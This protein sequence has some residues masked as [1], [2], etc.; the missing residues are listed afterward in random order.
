[1]FRQVGEESRLRGK[2]RRAPGLGPRRRTRRIAPPEV[3]RPVNE[4]ND[5]RTNGVS[6][7]SLA[8]FAN[9]AMIG[10]ALD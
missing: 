9:L 8:A 2:A 7:W 6:Q 1:M 4:M 5:V 10:N 3:L